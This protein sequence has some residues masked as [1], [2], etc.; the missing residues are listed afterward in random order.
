MRSIISVYY[1]HRATFLLTTLNLCTGFCPF[2]KW[3]SKNAIILNRSMSTRGSKET[4]EVPRV[5]EFA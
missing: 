3:V 1:T 2:I 4:R 5:T